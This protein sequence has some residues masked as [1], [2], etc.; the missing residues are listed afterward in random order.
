MI[1]RPPRGLKQQQ[2]AAEKAGCIF[3]AT[4]AINTLSHMFIRR[5]TQVSNYYIYIILKSGDW[6]TLRGMA[7][8]TGIELYGE[9]EG[10]KCNGSMAS[11]VVE[12]PGVF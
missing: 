8:W 12:C 4:V 1:Q 10:E 7:E 2:L 3:P 9:T 5:E 6:V 11:A